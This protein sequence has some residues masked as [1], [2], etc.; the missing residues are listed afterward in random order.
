MKNETKNCQNCKKDFTIEP[1]DFDFYKKIKVPPPTWCPVCRLKRRLAH[2]NERTLHKRRCDLCNE[3]IISVFSLNSPYTVYCTKCWYS[4]KWNPEDFG[5]DYDFTKPFFEQ[6][7]ELEKIVPHLAL[8]QENNI[9]S[10]WVNYESGD[11][12]CYL[13]IGG[14]SDQDCAYNQYALKSRDCFDN[15]WLMQS[16]FGY[17]NTLCENSYKNFGSVFC[18]E[19]QNAWFSFDCKNCSNVIGCSGLRHKKNFIFNKPVSKEEYEKFE[20]ENITG[21][22]KIFNKLKELS[23]KFWQEKPQRALF[24]DRSVTCTGNLIKDSKNCHEAWN[25]EKSENIKFG[26]FDLELKDSMD[27][28]SAWKSELG[29]EVMAAIYFSNA[30]FSTNLVTEN[31]NIFYSNFILGSNNCFGCSQL[32]HG[33][34][35]VLNKKYSKEEYLELLPKIIEHM[36]RTPYI[37][38]KGRT[39]KYGEFFPYEVSPFSYDETVA[40]EYFPLDDK[41]IEIEGANHFDYQ[42]NTKY[43]IEIISPPDAIADVDYSILDKAIKCEE[44]GKLFRIIKMELDFY[45]RFNLPLPTKSPLARHRNRLR[46]I[47]E[48][49][50]LIDRDC[51]KCDKKIKS[52]YKKEEFPIVFCEKCYQQEVY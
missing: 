43:D 49:L 45:K 6:F 48:H 35:M 50:K 27:V 2:R 8:F 28:T 19:C 9:N 23:K 3:D 10:P 20:R 16:E 42:I 17:E 26:I 40:C 47:S 51:G 24:I 37:D 21:S 34:Y 14:H 11:K 15:F 18:F 29:Y 1:E 39:Y 36:N 32:K 7:I 13:N 44:T 52:I 41:E 25:V 31:T 12:N 33:E 5:K 22:R 46:F 4:D 38:K 30:L